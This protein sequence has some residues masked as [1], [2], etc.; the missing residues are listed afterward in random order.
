MSSFL[1]E[2]G[3]SKLWGNIKNAFYTKTE[4]DNKLSEIQG[5]SGSGGGNYPIG[6]V[7]IG[8]IN[9]SPESILGGTWELIDKEFTPQTVTGTFTINTATSCE[10]KASLG[11]HS[12]E[13][14]LNFK[15][16]SAIADSTVTIGTLTP[17]SVGVTEFPKSLYPTGSSDGGNAIC[18]CYFSTNGVFQILDGNP[19]GSSLTANQAT[20][21]IITFAIDDF[22][23]MVDSFCNK[24]YWK[25]TA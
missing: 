5:G 7:Y 1:D 3:L 10:A 19:T 20:Y 17:S 2:T 16:K 13:L 4:I 6:S 8:T 22:A 23:T 14:Q 18:A 12:I 25:R 15:A 9:T 11:G 21:V 24:F